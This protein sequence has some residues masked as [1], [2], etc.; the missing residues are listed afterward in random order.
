MA[1][2]DSVAVSTAQMGAAVVAYVSGEVAEDQGLLA[3][4]LFSHL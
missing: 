1:S 2:E 3:E 4:Q